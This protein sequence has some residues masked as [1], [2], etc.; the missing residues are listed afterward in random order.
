MAQGLEW[1]ERYK[2][3][4]ERHEGWAVIHID[5][6]G[7]FG[8]VSDYGNYAFHWTS[9]GEDFKEFL[10]GLDWDYLYGKLTHTQRVYD[11]DGTE[12][13]IKQHILQRRHSRQMTREQARDEW[14]LLDE[15]EVDHHTDVGYA[16]WRARTELNTYEGDFYQTMHEPQCRQF[17]EKVFPR[18]IQALR[19]GQH[20][21]LEGH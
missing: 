10:V 6:K 3:P 7:F 9:F 21:R 2:I 16:L 17:C 11:G 14:A 20:E 15:S 19:A 13:S 5:S 4:N 18:F 1:I 8:V 12:R